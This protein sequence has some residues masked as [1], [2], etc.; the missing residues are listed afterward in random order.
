[1][2]VT[3]LL[4]AITGFG[5]A[6]LFLPSVV[7]SAA[8]Y[9]DVA[10]VALIGGGLTVLVLYFLPALVAINRKIARGAGV[11]FIANPLAGRT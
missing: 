2:K 5:I 11:V 1:V 10:S 6:T 9:P 4:A 8:Q 7:G 3:A